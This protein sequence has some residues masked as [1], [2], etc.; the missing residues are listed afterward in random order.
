L[1]ITAGVLDLD[2][3]WRRVRK[4]LEARRVF[5]RHPFHDTL[6]QAEL[7]SWLQDLTGQIQRG[8]YQPRPCA[9]VPM[10]K[11]GGLT[12]PGGDLN[13]ADQVVFA[14]L[15]QQLRPLI[16]GAI[17]DPTASPDYA[18]HLRANST[19]DEWFEPHFQRWLA[20]A[21]DSVVEIDS[22][23]EF[24]V[25]ADIS[26]YY[27]AIDLWTLRSDLNGLGVQSE[28][29]RLLMECLNRWARVQSRG[30]PQGF[31][32]ADILAK[33]YLNSVDLSLRAACFRHRRWVDDFRIFCHD[34]AEA[35]RA[36]VLLAEVLGSRG[37]V[38]QTA[39]SKVLS[40][41][42]ARVKFDEVR[43]LL[44]PIQ[45]Q[46]AAEVATGDAGQSSVLPI[47]EVD[48]VLSEGD[49]EEAVDVVREAYTRHFVA[50]HRPP[51]N[52]SL[53]HFLL[54]RLAAA[55]D[56]TH[57]AHIIM[58]LRDHVEELDAIAKYCR[59]VGHAMAFEDE[60]LR[61]SNAELLPYPYATY[62]FLRWRVRGDEPLSLVLRTALL[63]LALQPG[64]PWFVR[65][66]ARALLG[67]HGDGA[68][69]ARLEAAY[70]TAQSDVEKAELLCAVHRMEV[71][72][73]N[74]LYGRAAGDGDLCSRAVRMSRGGTVNFEAC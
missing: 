30:L 28:V 73:R 72:R 52:K 31:S 23:A 46:L 62:Q 32:P 45:A 54:L 10:P 27:E 6:L 16:A 63:E 53:F 12:R 42:A 13:L 14:A 41:V 40:G 26:G 61:L 9:I 3:A 24:V 8:E 21:R 5:A 70:P 20:F 19:H 49:A 68:D 43:H 69:L 22:G 36:L 11:P 64:V 56:V 55:H 7:D 34:E 66:S 59:A 47:W 51:F 74:S 35:R 60:F 71:G 18:Y 17:G 39:K 38:L 48:Q 65:A 29:L 57:L 4:D 58:Q 2:L 37:L 67:K 44:S 1:P 33:L 50:D 15:V 25:V